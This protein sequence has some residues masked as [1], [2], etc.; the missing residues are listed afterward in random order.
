MTPQTTA[1][2]Q[3]PPLVHLTTHHPKAWDSTSTLAEPPITSHGL[4]T[5]P[6]QPM[7]RHETV[8]AKDS[9]ERLPPYAVEEGL[10][11]YIHTQGLSKAAKAIRHL[12]WFGFIFP[13]LWIIGAS[14]LLFF[15]KGP[16]QSPSISWL[17]TRSGVQTEGE[18]PNWSVAEAIRVERLWARRCTWAMTISVCA[19]ITTVAAIWGERDLAKRPHET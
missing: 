4:P 3:V 1:T 14:T 9:S 2:I 8:D 16:S 12:F 19:V 6:V 13:P 10:P 15:A 5:L 7:P 11:T 18:D 17:S